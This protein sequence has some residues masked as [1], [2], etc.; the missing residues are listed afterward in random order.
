MNWMDINF[1]KPFVEG[2]YL[3]VKENKLTNY[4]DVFIDEWLET[5][6]VKQKDDRKIVKRKF[7]FLTSNDPQLPITHWMKIPTYWKNEKLYQPPSL[8]FKNFV[9]MIGQ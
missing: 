7:K 4:I 5:F 9:T 2:K 8:K 6:V 1:Q 3:V